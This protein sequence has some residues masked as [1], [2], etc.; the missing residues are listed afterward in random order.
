MAGVVLRGMLGWDQRLELYGIK[1]DYVCA[2]HWTGYLVG[3]V[4]SFLYKNMSIYKNV[5]HLRRAAR[6]QARG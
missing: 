3:M 1:V 6:W 4:G 2:P 5:D